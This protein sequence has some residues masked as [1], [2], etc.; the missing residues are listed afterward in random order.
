MNLGGG[1]RL[2]CRTLEVWSCAS[3]QMLRSTLWWPWQSGAWL[4]RYTGLKVSLEKISKAGIVA[5][6]S[7]VTLKMLR[8][9]TPVRRA[10]GCECQRH[11]VGLRRQMNWTF[12]W[13]ILSWAR[14]LATPVPGDSW[15]A[16]YGWP[17]QNIL[18]SMEESKVGSGGVKMCM[19]ST[20]LCMQ[21]GNVCDVHRSTFAIV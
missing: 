15:S 8:E 3:S 10:G 19:H 14:T 20:M 21:T 5:G 12:A 18:A 2:T 16:F 7:K 11:G 9:K 4:R 17:D 6:L 13:R 1:S